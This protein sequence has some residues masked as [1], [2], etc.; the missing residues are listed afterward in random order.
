MYGLRFRFKPIDS[1]LRDIDSC[2]ERLITFGDADFFGVKERAIEVMKALKGRGVRWQAGVNAAVSEDDRLLELAAESGCF[3]LCI[4]FES[5][6]KTTLRNVHKCQNNPEAYQKLV[7]KI[8]S[9]GLMVLGLFIVGFDED[10]SSVFGETTH[11]CIDSDYDS[12][13]FSIFTPH[14]GTVTWFN[15]MNRRQITSFDWDAYDQ[16][17]VVYQPS[18][19]SQRDLR[20]GYKQTFDDF[21]S[22]CSIARRFPWKSQGRSRTLWAIHN[23]FYRAIGTRAIDPAKIIAD[24][25]PPP[26]ALAEPPIPPQRA[27]WRRLIEANRMFGVSA[28]ETE[29]MA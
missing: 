11:F 8:H 10:D 24:P 21:Y 17:H 14:P 16:S 20:D 25:T 18:N 13:A 4:G 12:C 23:L 15:M 27:A 2:G 26:V 29:W 5:V 28:H 1:I 22:V 7:A 6:S 19:M 9:H 3:Q